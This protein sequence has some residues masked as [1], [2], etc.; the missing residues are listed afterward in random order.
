MY[1][2]QVIKPEPFRGL[3]RRSGRYWLLVLRGIG[4]DGDFHP[5]TF[6]G[7]IFRLSGILGYAHVQLKSYPPTK[8]NIIFTQN[9]APYIQSEPVHPRLFHCLLSLKLSE[10]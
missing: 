6:Y 7:G 8:I 10:F 9:E 3:S 2:V 1:C 4:K 5:F